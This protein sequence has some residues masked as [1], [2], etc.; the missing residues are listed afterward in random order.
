MIPVRRSMTPFEWSLVVLLSVLWGGSF[1]FIGVAV[2][3]LPPLTIVA[4]RLGLAALVF[5]A[6]F[7]I[8]GRRLP[9]GIAVWSAFTIMGILANVLPFSL[10][11]IAE[12]RIDSGLAAILYATTPL[13]AVFAA[14]FLTEDEKLTGGKIVGALIGLAGVAVL[15]G[16]DA[17]GALTAGSDLLP[18]LA[19]IGAALSNALSGIYGRRFAR[20]GI[21]PD[22]AAAG[23]LTAAAVILIV[24]AAL[25]ERPW[26]GAM[27]GTA[28]WLSIAG[29]A[30]L[31]TAVA[32][33][34]FYRV[35]ATAGATNLML[36]TLLIP[37][38]ASLLGVLVLKEVVGLSELAGLVLIATSLLAID[39]R[40]W[41]RLRP[42][43]VR[44]PEAQ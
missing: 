32:Y 10:I 8:S 14:H 31:S 26:Q 27:P 22:R 35:L 28:T 5:L 19:V 37:V 25:L 6:V 3:E 4:L 29:L 9:G 7:A 13:F 23:Q 20:L 30:F 17:V 2:H 40:L 34:V 42:R 38:S 21:S 12:T 15:I 1:F 36:V 16:P 43:P 41:A 18:E 33:L 11:T 24:L 39:G 44:A